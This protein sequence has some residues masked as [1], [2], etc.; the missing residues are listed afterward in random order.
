MSHLLPFYAYR[1]FAYCQL[2]FCNFT[3]ASEQPKTPAAAYFEMHIQKMKTSEIR[4]DSIIIG[5]ILQIFP[6]HLLSYDEKKT[7][8]SHEA[9]RLLCKKKSER[10][11]YIIHAIFTRRPVSIVLTNRF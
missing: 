2:A 8:S 10:S 4:I 6:L 7:A 9:F 5:N 1:Q 3:T 11:G